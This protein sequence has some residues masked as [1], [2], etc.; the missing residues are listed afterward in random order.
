MRKSFPESISNKRFARHPVNLSFFRF[1][2]S[3]MP[4]EGLFA[5]AAVGTCGSDVNTNTLAR[6]SLVTDKLLSTSKTNNV[7]R[8]A[9]LADS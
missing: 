1:P 3:M 2:E 9:Q 8:A 7:R 5:R 6:H 4:E